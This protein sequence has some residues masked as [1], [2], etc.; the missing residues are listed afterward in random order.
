MNTGF[1]S[2]QET[3]LTYDL[4]GIVQKCYKE[5]VFTDYKSLFEADVEAVVA[6][7]EH[8]VIYGAGANGIKTSNLFRRKGI[9]LQGFMVSD[10]QPKQAEK[11]GLPIYRL[12]EFPFEKEGTMVVVSVAYARSRNAIV[13][14]LRDGGFKHYFLL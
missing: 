4:T 7:Y 5:H 3:N 9:A 10:D 2:L 1:A 6:G 8:V 14:N 11:N 12:S 13:K